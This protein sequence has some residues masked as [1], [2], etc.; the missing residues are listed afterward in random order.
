MKLQTLAFESLLSQCLTPRDPDSHKGDF[1]HVL[2]VGGDRGMSGAPHLAALAA[3]RV[4]AGMVS[5]ATHP[6]HA[7]FMAAVHP[8]LMVH[9]V[10]TVVSLMALIKKAT[11]LVLG[12]GLG[13]SFW[14]QTLWKAVN[15]GYEGPMVVDADGL[16]L[17]A[18]QGGHREN[19][20]LTP[21]VGEAARL[22]KTES[23]HVQ[24]HRLE[25]VK[26]LQKTYGGVSV[27]KG[28][29]T[30]VCDGSQL[31]EN[32]YGNPGMA[33]AGMGDLLSGVIAGLLAQGLTVSDAAALGVAL[34]GKAGD[35][36]AQG[37]ERGLITTDLLPHL[38]TLVG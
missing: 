38:R 17:L 14:S 9:E 26:A 12:P 10:E 13:Q 31:L 35:L 29:R 32:P 30:L 16:N 18:Q 4:G 25:E 34:H 6:T 3:L 20:I 33:T 19:W 23:A 15:Q 8:E 27:L 2:V 24:A 36:A 37:G 5:I 22:L 11:V 1:G 28:A 21:H 7:N